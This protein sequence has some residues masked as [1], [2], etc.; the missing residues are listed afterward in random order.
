M[1]SGG[2][3]S[4][5]SLFMNKP[6]IN[7]VFTDDWELRGNGS[8]DM[9]RLQ[10][11]PMKRLL[12]IFDKHGVRSTFMAEVMQQV[13]FRREQARH[14][15]LGLMADR[16]DEH[17]RDAYSR[18]H[19]V[20][21]HV[22]SQWSKAR[23]ENGRWMLDGEW[24]LLKCTPETIASM[25]SRGKSYLEELFCPIDRGYRCVAFRASYLA[26]APSPFMLRLLAEHGI[27]LDLSIVGGLKVN[28][29]HVHLDYTECDEDLVP[30]YPNMNDARRVSAEPEP[31]VCVP[32]FHFTGSRLSVAKQI[33]AKIID[34]WSNAP[35]PSA[36]LGLVQAAPDPSVELGRASMA[37]QAMDKIIRPV[38]F[39]KHLTADVGQFG[40]R[41][42]RE[43]I[44]AVRRKAARSG[45][46]EL[47]VV[48]TNHTKNMRDFAGFD[49]FLGEITDADDI[50]F[51][52]AAELAAKVRSGEFAVRTSN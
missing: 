27:E 33:V 12:D 10:F 51:I 18:G 1:H 30:F 38:L 6:V 16:W 52:T 34:R 5:I 19:D 24:S 26:V 21:L 31:I 22:H 45:L 39:G 44:S 9:D 8:G 14:A 25:V 29:R 2:I 48:I 20:Q 36:K 32:I 40:L 37:S 28:T 13:T 42:L 41:L 3:L 7:L 50:R 49:R 17:V 35:E 43:M 23:F 15:E 11:E 47:P 46:A 4:G